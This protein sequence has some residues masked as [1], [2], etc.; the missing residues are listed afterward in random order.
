LKLG[1]IFGG[2]SHKVDA[3]QDSENWRETSGMKVRARIVGFEIL[4]RQKRLT[5]IT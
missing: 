1:V 2:S 5:V 4:E 3:D